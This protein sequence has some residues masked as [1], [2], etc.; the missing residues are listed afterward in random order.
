MPGTEITAVSKT[1]NRKWGKDNWH[2]YAVYDQDSQ[3]D[4]DKWTVIRGN[5]THNTQKRICKKKRKNHEGRKGTE[6]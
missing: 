3:Q 2:K 4:R 5:M 1:Q 6:T